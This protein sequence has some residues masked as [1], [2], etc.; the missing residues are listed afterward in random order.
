MGGKVSNDISPETIDQIW[1]QKFIYTPAKGV[2]RIVN[3]KSVKRIV[4]FESLKF[5][6][7]CLFLSFW[8]FNMLVNGE[9]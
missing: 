6:Q 1:S 9:L 2:K 4:K 8:P 7:I 3:T 5:W